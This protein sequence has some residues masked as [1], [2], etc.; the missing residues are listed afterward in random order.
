MNSILR[1][2]KEKPLLAGL[3]VLAVFS[4]IFVLSRTVFAPKQA[5]RYQAAKVERGSIVSTVT[6]S[7]SVLSSNTLTITTSATGVVKEVLVHDGDLVTAGQKL[8]TIALDMVGNQKNAAAWSSYLSA[9]NSLDNANANLFS[10]QSTMFSKWK[11]YTDLATNST[12]QNSDGTPNT[13]NRVLTQFSTAQDDW[14]AAEAAYKNL[15]S[16]IAQAQAAV[17]S[18]W[19]SYQASAPVV[20]APMAGNV[21]NI[22]IVPGLVLSGTNAQNVAVIQSDSLPIATFNISEIDVSSV[23]PG[24]KATITLDSIAGKTFAGTVETVDRI[25]TVTSGVTNYPVIIRFDT[26]SL[27]LLPNMSA[28]V[29]IITNQK[30]NV[31]LVPAMAVV[32]QNGQSV[33]RVLKNNTVTEVPVETGL[34]SNSQIEITSGVNEGDTVVTGTATGG[35]SSGSPSPFGGGNRGFGGGGALRVGGFGTGSGGGGR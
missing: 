16:A 12:Y 23:E 7:G 14:F 24:Q 8:A 17:T 15:Q 28:T 26:K 11:T 6:A 3:V 21:G 18:A 5:A 32:T 20:T 4:L 29:N 19:A 31:L 30:D 10:L 27:E 33:V 22:T 25:G 9:K 1:F 34:S 13:A 35:Q 2:I